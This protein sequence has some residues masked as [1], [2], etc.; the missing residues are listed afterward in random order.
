MLI[1]FTVLLGV[2]YPFAVW[3]VGQVIFPYQ[4]NGSLI[5]NSKG[6]VI[7]SELIGQN[8]SSPRLLSFPAVGGGKRL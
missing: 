1:V 4:A 7:G 3:G 2:L 6:E 5:K 8:F